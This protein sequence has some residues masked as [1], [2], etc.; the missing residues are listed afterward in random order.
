MPLKVKSLLALI[1]VLLLAI[2]WEMIDY[3]V[4]QS[5]VVPVATPQEVTSSAEP[6]NDEESVFEQPQHEIWQDV[7][8]TVSRGDVEREE[9]VLEY[10][11]DFVV[12]GYCPCS[13]C[14]GQWSHL[15]T[16]ITASGA[17]AV[18]GVTVAADWEVL[19]PGTVIVIDGIGRRIVQDRGGG[20]KGMTLDL[21]H[22]QHPDALAFS[23]QTLKVWRVTE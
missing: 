12:F 2:T 1:A 3:A 10:L 21:Y 6:Q 17:P 23:K 13:I 4:F 5:P 7:T 20:I 16:P 8:A 22:E 19:P 9:P 18:E 15:G 14:C 11:G